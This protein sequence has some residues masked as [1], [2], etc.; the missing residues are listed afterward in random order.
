MILN[1][2]GVL[3]RVSFLLT[4]VFLHTKVVVIGVR[5]M[6][7]SDNYLKESLL[8]FNSKVKFQTVAQL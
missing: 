7:S 4:C 1:A 3:T 8:L 6:F 5:Y 2:L